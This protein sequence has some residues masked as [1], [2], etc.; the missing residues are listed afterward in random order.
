MLRTLSAGGVGLLA[1]VATPLTPDSSASTD[2]STTPP[3]DLTWGPCEEGIGEPL[4]CATLAVPLDYDDP[5]GPTIDLAVIRYPAN[6]EVREGAILLNPGGPGGS[7]YDFASA[8]AESLDFG[9]GLAGHFDIVGF[10]PR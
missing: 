3:G 8:A 9:L 4:E 6:P 5:T 10:D 1:I 2:S 7:G